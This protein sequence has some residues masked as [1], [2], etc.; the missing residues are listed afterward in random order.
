MLDKFLGVFSIALLVV[1]MGIVVWYIDKPALTTIVVLVLLM[2]AYD[3]WRDLW[4]AKKPAA[5]SDA[6][7]GRS[8]E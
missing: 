6:T 4:G 5:G 2:A 8:S 3:F 7:D 1:F